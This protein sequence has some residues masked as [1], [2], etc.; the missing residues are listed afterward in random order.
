MAQATSVCI[1]GA[2]YAE[3][4]FREGITRRPIEGKK[5]EPQWNK[6]AIRTRQMEN[7]TYQATRDAFGQLSDGLAPSVLHNVQ[8]VLNN[9]NRSLCPAIAN[10]IEESLFAG[11]PTEVSEKSIV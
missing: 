4:N 11:K 2:C 9:R 3:K 7:L 5:R 6:Q 10:K 8:N 1:G